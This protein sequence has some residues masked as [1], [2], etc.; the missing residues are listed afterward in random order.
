[1]PVLRRAPQRSALRSRTPRS[2]GERD[3]DGDDLVTCS[4]E[5]VRFLTRIR[6]TSSTYASKPH[7]IA[8][9]YFA[10]ACSRVSYVKRRAYLVPSFLPMGSM[11]SI[12][13]TIVISASGDASGSRFAGAGGSEMTSTGGSLPTGVIS[14]EAVEPPVDASKARICPS[15]CPMTGSPPSFVEDRCHRS[16]RSSIRRTSLALGSDRDREGQ[17]AAMVS[18]AVGVPTNAPTRPGRRLSKSSIVT[19]SPV[20]SHRQKTEPDSS[21]RSSHTRPPSDSAVR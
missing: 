7:R 17:R 4:C 3:A 10:H 5:D 20:G 16:S 15:V 6:P 2:V 12:A 9:L 8:A 19:T 21:D 1:M 14:I 11:T 18:Q 13:K